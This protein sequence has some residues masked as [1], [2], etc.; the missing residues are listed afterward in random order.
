MPEQNSCIPP[1]IILNSFG[2][3]ARTHP[4]T[5]LNS[6]FTEHITSSLCPNVAEIDVRGASP[7]LAFF[8]SYSG[9]PVLTANWSDSEWHLGQVLGSLLASGLPI[10]LG[11]RAYVDDAN[12][13]QTIQQVFPSTGCCPHPPSL[14]HAA[15]FQLLFSRCNLILISL[16][17][18]LRVPH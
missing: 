3:I 16:H 1:N 11:G 4:T 2:L 10:L 17:V 14:L 9:M 15:R 5:A 12:S 6:I 7:L 8:D 18:C 13:S